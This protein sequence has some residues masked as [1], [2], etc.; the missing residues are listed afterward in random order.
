MALTG[1]EV[2]QES[3]NHSPGAIF[4]V[5]PLLGEGERVCYRG[6]DAE[7]IVFRLFLKQCLTLFK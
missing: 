6:L 3:M 1:M 7:L 2:A 5:L 4:R